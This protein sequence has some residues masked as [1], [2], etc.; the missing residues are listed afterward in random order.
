MSERITSSFHVKYLQHFGKKLF[1]AS[2]LSLMIIKIS[3]SCYASDNALAKP[4]TN[5]NV[6][7]ENTTKLADQP[8]ATPNKEASMDSDEDSTLL[9][10]VWGVRP[11]LA[12]YGF[13]LA[14]EDIN[15]LWGNPYGGVKQGPAYQ[16]I[17]TVTLTWDP[18]KLLGIKHGQFNV[19]MLQIRG[20]SL[21]DDNLGDLNSVSN[22]DAVR[23][24]R[25][26]ELWYQQG[27][28]D[29]KLNV[30]IGKIALDS[31]FNISD[32][33]LL[34]LNS[35]F[36]WS[37]INTVDTF[38]TG[39][40]Y[41]YS[42]PGIR[43]NFTPNEHWTNLLAITDDNPSNVSICGPS[44]AFECDDQSKKH[45]SGT[46]FNFTGGVFVIN[47]VQYHLNPATDTSK[48][49]GYPGTYRFGVF[50]DSAGFADQ[51]Y[52][53]QKQLL[54]HPDTEQTM[55]KH[56][57][58]WSIYA[59]VDQMIW[60]SPQDKKQA[61]GIFGKVQT[62]PGD[63]NAISFAADAGIVL[64]GLFNKEGNSIGL[65]WG[66]GSFSNR[67]RQYDRDYRRYSDDTWRVRK[68]EHHIE[69]VTQIEVMP[70]LQLTPDFQYIFNPGGG[71]NLD[72]GSHKRIPNEAVFGL[73]STVD[74]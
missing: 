47:E 7:G 16:G 74:F 18:E 9:G 59:I 50:F 34:F 72:E 35:S 45:R 25:L 4:N 37:M 58:N 55:F 46:H 12:Q 28:W 29:D 61:L 38:N 33:G 10:S 11:W 70:W 22:M 30:R 20:R 64:K 66:V 43:F 52:N 57:H 71:L 21:G 3:S 53:A 26:W 51:R 31:E 6:T 62:A 36:G 65:G 24:T 49:T 41:P 69:L 39:V 54:G 1:I 27:F 15:D 56:D 19:S 68:T 32:Y 5:Q 48:E 14:A 23:S 44:G 60:R 13:A 63:R 40:E 67:A 73:R 8:T 2:Q 17:T 42:A